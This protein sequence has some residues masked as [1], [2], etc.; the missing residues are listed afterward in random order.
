MVTIV[1]IGINGWKEY[2]KPAIDSILK[3]EPDDELIVIDNASDEPYPQEGYVM[4]T[5]RMSY[6]EAINTAVYHTKG[7]WIL[8]MNN[9]VICNDHFAEQVQALD[10]LAIHGRQIITEDGHVWLGNWIAAFTRKVFWELDGFDKN[11]AMCGFEDAD[12]CVR[13]AKLGY[14][15]RF[16]DLPFFHL[17]GKTRWQLPKY[18]EVRQK[19][20]DYFEQK[21]GFRL[22]ENLR[23]THY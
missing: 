20:M 10:P 23:V 13:A 14:P 2:T 4:R 1:I 3:Y 8:A 9:D 11:F 17:W 22:G 21:H 16:A 7:D 5:E 12:L 6:A 19:N 15:T 18:P